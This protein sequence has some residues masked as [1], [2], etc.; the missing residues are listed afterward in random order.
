MF[1][2]P[3][4]KECEVAEGPAEW[5]CLCTVALQV[6]LGHLPT[7]RQAPKREGS[8]CRLVTILGGFM[9]DSHKEEV[10][11]EGRVN[12]LSNERVLPPGP[13]AAF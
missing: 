8:F 12:T 1:Q 2:H 4:M 9:M 6:G 13:P 10:F 3:Q 11:F 5:R 7:G